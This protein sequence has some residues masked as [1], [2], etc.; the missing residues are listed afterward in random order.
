[1]ATNASLS[2]RP[3][4]GRGKGDA[5]K[6][7]ASGQIPAVV[8][9]HNEET[10]SVEVDAHELERLF[11]TVHVENTII[12]LSIEGEAQAVRTLVREVQAHPWRGHVLHVDFYQIHAGEKLEVEI[13]IRLIGDA[14]GVK[15]GGVLSANINDLEVRCLPDA[16]PEFIEVDISGLHIGDAIHVSDLPLPE[17]VESLVD[18]ERTVCTVT[19]PTVLK[20][21]EEEEAEAEA[22]EAAELAAEGEAP[23]P[24]VIGKGREEEEDKED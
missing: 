1:M 13:P 19:P 4:S 22:A 5:R 6:L 2:A 24:E 16:I 7:R 21:L 18:A 20:T 3:R 8:Y 11:A 23:E 12:D 17:G 15:E 14:P 9:G 10:R